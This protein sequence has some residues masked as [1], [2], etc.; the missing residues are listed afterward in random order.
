VTDSYG[1]FGPGEISGGSY[2][3]EVRQPGFISKGQQIDIIKNGQEITVELSYE[4]A[5]VTVFVQDTDKK[6]ISGARIAANDRDIGATDDH[7]QLATKLKINTHY[8]ISASKEG[9]SPAVTDK[10][11]LPGSVSS[12][13]TLTLEKTLDWGFIALMAAGAIAVIAVF[14]AIRFMG[15]SGP[16]RHFRK[17][18]L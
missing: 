16:K 9:Y 12:T 6:V 5:D 18:G 17:E 13:V 8:N 11:V 2:Q 3:I 1:R 15:R 10:L 4:L 7:G 14:A